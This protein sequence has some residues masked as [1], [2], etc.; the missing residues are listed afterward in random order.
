MNTVLFLCS[1]NYYRSRFAEHQ[2]NAIADRDQLPWRADSRG[3][4]VGPG[5]Q[6]RADFPACRSWA[7]ATGDSPERQHSVPG[8]GYGTGTRPGEL[9]HR[10][11]GNRAP[12]DAGGAVS[13]VGGSR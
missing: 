3:L 6:H 13:G 10:L 9:D 11:E 12:L 4:V 1:G 2:F 8:A 5:R 7:G